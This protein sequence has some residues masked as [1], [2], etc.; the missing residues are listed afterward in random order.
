MLVMASFY[1]MKGIYQCLQPPFHDSFLVLVMYCLWFD[2]VLPSLTS[3]RVEADENYYYVTNYF[4]T[5]RYHK[6]D[7]L[8]I[9]TM[10][11]GIW[12]WNT[13]VMKKPPVSAGASVSLAI[14]RLLK[15]RLRLPVLGYS[16]QRDR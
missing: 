10:D 8:E 12:K 3:K 13:M 7:V 11:L 2:V 15:N 16:L 4:K 5:Y 6:D 1:P 9:K 14:H